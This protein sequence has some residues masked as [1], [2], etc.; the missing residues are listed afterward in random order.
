MISN[1][2]RRLFVVGVTLGLPASLA[3]QS[4]QQP[5]ACS[6]SAYR[7]FDFW[8]GQWDVTN[9]QGAAAGTNTITRILQGCV[10]HESWASAGGSPGESH[11]IYN[12]QTGQWHQTWVDATGTL[13]Q[14]DGGLDTEGK[15]VLRGKTLGQG[16]QEVLNEISWEPLASGQVRQVWRTS[17]D[18]GAHWQIVFDGLYTRKQ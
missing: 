6:A 4:N 13:L 3:G 14:L 10:L 17:T 12:L 16:G 7:Q 11:N 15:M 8:I 2:V 5:A 1:I 18:E 9:P